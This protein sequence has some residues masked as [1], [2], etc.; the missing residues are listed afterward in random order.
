MVPPLWIAV[1]ALLS[2]CACTGRCNYKRC[3]VYNY[4]YWVTWE[5]S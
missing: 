2:T 3:A 1:L 5:G 4:A